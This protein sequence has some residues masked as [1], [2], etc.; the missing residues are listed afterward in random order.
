MFL[1][2]PIF[3]QS[4]FC[5]WVKDLL[6]GDFL[7][8]PHYTAL[9]KANKYVYGNW[10]LERM[11][12]VEL[13]SSNY[14]VYAFNQSLPNFYLNGGIKKELHYSNI[15][16]FTFGPSYDG[17]NINWN[18]ETRKKIS[19]NLLGRICHLLA[20]MSV[21]AHVHGTLHVPCADDAYE[22]WMI[23][24]EGK[25]QYWNADKVYEERGGFINPYCSAEHGFYS[26]ID[27][28]FYTMAQITQHYA[29]RA[30]NGNDNYNHNIG[31]IKSILDT[32]GDVGP[33][34]TNGMMYNTDN[35]NGIRETTIPYL[36][37]ATA[38]LFYWFLVETGY[39]QPNYTK[40]HCSQLVKMNLSNQYINGDYYTFSCGITDNQDVTQGRITT[41]PL[42][43]QYFTIGSNARN[44][45]FN[46]P[47]EIILK[48]G[49]TILEGSD[50][51]FKISQCNDCLD[52]EI[53]PIYNKR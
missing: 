16:P 49:T 9:F 21:P 14:V 45:T 51:I 7:A 23:Y 25:I 36:I 31:E 50:V 30:V 6:L 34:T 44:V 53:N 43:D 33:T 2:I 37:R 46:A 32:Y 20:D 17:Y 42:Q 11:E 24:D 13:N 12:N 29:S 4:S 10:F 41:C 19:Y 18:L 22:D 52:Q 5:A 38:G 3:L 8:K 15:G 26:P 39:M 40:Q 48:P 28:L 27:F 35:M 47:K 1:N